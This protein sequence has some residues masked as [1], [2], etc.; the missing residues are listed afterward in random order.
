MPTRKNDALNLAT[1]EVS[2]EL[3]LALVE[4]EFSNAELNA[5]DTSEDGLRAL[6]ESWGLDTSDLIIGDVYRFV[7]DKDELIDVPFM[8]VQWKFGVSEG[9]GSRYVQARGVITG[10]NEKI[11]LFDSG[12]GIA[13]QLWELSEDRLKKNRE[14]GKYLKPPYNGAIA[15]KGLT[16]SDYPAKTQADGTVRPAGTT[17]YIA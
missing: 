13:Q 8:I 9:Y 3:E 2:D 6:I 16:R 15:P 10:T 4:P 5:L 12:V 11:G 1:G 17:Y 7:E 14:A